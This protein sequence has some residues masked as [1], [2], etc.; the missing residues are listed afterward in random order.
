MLKI[1]SIDAIYQKL[2]QIYPQ[3]TITI[4]LDI[5]GHVLYDVR[6]PTTIEIS[7]FIGNEWNGYRKVK[8]SEFRKFNE[9]EITSY[10]EELDSLQAKMN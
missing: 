5:S 10:M 3:R 9:S 1:I 8:S 7:V 2:C 4:G 6:Q